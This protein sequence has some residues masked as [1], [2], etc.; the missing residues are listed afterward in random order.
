MK[1]FK[2]TFKYKFKSTTKIYTFKIKIFF[3]K[4]RSYL[5]LKFY[6][7]V[8]TKKILKNLVSFYLT[9]LN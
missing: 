3:Y 8:G 4:L 9:T 1:I 2:I 5:K 7:Y 6:F